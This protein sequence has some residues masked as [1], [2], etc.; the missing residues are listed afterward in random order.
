MGRH[1]KK[2]LMV[3]PADRV[4]IWNSFLKLSW[5]EAKLVYECSSGRQSQKTL[6]PLGG[7][8]PDDEFHALA[9]LVL[10]TLAIEAR[11]N[12]L[13]N[14]LAEQGKITQDVAEAARWLPIKH[15]WFLIPSLAGVQ[16]T[17]DSSTGPHQAVAQICEWRNDL[18]H[19]DYPSL[20]N[21]LPSPDTILS[22][23][24]RFVEAM[25]DMNVVLGRGI[26]RP[27]KEVLDIGVFD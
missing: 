3:D 22:Y 9:T 5:A 1:S 25:E 2:S 23:F 20:K 27:R 26:D 8:L 15:R 14:E 11:A 18:F 4:E 19:V 17:F 16:S 6:E 21:G 10:C 12:H 24:R 7:T 13:I